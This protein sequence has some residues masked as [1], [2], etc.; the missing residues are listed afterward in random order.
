MLPDGCDAALASR[1]R[2]QLIQMFSL[3]S[4][5]SLVLGRKQFSGVLTSFSLTSLLLIFKK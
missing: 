2:K 5:F 3:L 1:V 4:V